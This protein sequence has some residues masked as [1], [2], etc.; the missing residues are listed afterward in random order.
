[1]TLAP[2]TFLVATPLLLDPQFHQAVVMLINH[3]DDGTFGLVINHP[4]SSSL[5]D[6]LGNNCPASIGEQPLFL[7]GP[8]ETDSLFCLHN[9]AGDFEDILEILPGIHFGA[10]VSII[11]SYAFESPN[12]SL[13]AHFFCGYSGWGA[14]QL[15]A[16][17][18]EGSWAIYD[19]CPTDILNNEVSHLW[20]R[21]MGSTHSQRDQ[22]KYN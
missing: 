14:G 2:G 5:S 3:D 4:S 15:Q 8:V 21:Y 16:E 18:E 6:A 20:P 17:I 13:K 19:G 11:D 9:N 10:E 12:P 1:M 22:A 7:G